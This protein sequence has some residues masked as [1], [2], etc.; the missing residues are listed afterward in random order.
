M[1][2]GKIMHNERQKPIFTQ[3]KVRA[4]KQVYTHTQLA[5]EQSE[6]QMTQNH[7]SGIMGRAEKQGKN[8]DATF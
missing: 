7:G 6:G 2:N 1:P 3:Q 8:S 4:N 5:P